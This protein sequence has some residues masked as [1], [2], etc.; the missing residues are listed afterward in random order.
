MRATAPVA[1]LAANILIGEERPGVGI[2]VRQA[3]VPAGLDELGSVAVDGLQSLRVGKAV[4][5][6]TVPDD[7]ACVIGIGIEFRN[8]SGR[9]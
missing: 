1:L 8:R 4:A 6:G 5:P 7:V 3:E 9:G 2:R